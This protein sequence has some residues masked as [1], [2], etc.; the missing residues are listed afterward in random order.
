MQ[1]IVSQHDS[2]ST[3]SL[4]M[5][6]TVH[7]LSTRFIQYIVPQHDSYSTLSLNIINTVHCL[8]TR[9]I[10]YIVP[11]HD[12]Y[13]TLSLSMIHSLIIQY[14]VSQHDSYSTL[15]LNMI[16]TVHFFSASSLQYIISQHDSYSTL[17]LNIFHTVRRLSTR[18]LQYIVFQHDSYITLSLNTIP[19]MYSY[20]TLYLNTIPT[21]LYMYSPLGI[22]HICT[23]H[24]LRIIHA[25]LYIH[26]LLTRFIQYMYVVSLVSTASI[27]YHISS[28]LMQ[29]TVSQHD[30]YSM[31]SLSLICTEHRLSTLFDMQYICSKMIHT[32]QCLPTRFM[33]YNISQ[34]YSYNTLPL[35]T[36]HTIHY[37]IVFEY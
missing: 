8:S 35:I 3:L 29:C 36:I 31:L 26:C 4:N 25:V 30:L 6:H 13:S 20:N 17:S 37:M 14:I 34:N 7:C 22:I 19:T 18:F 32:V 12:S 2:Y 15:S 24:H 11:Q 9:F 28:S 5:I 21:I 33:L 10:Q 23:L 27:P 16:H 1:Y